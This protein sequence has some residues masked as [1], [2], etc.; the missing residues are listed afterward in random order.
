MI[1]PKP[2][3]ELLQ[4]VVQRVNV[5]VFV[6]DRQY[7]VCY[8]NNFMASHSLKSAFDV[9]GRNLF[10]TF[11]DL[12]V[13][14]FKKKIDSVFVVKSYAFTT[15]E[16]RN[17]LFKFK[18]NRPITG[19]AEYMF[20]NLTLIPIKN[21]SNGDVDQVMV[22]LRDST[23]EACYASKL[24]EAM[25]ELEH[26]SQVDGLTG[27]YNRIHW[28]QRMA[29]EFA[30]SRRYGTT[31]SLL[32]IDIDH[33]KKINDEFGHLAG[34][35]VIRMVAKLI[36]NSSRK[37]DIAGRYGGEEFGILLCETGITGAVI[38][39]ERLRIR[40]ADYALCLDR[41]GGEQHVTVSVG[42]ARYQEGM[43]NHEQVLARS[44]E[45][46]YESKQN[47]RNRVTVCQEDRDECLL[48]TPKSL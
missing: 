38:F 27:L 48:N 42:I 32:M 40:I 6:V 18:H 2:S 14:W 47:G 44:D 31:F 1:D 33:F 28:E 11:P 34:D 39:A 16:Y 46:L 26:L 21:E 19:G 8:W 3:Y 13:R 45:A 43:R 24:R 25:A 10:D 15:W 29:A 9:V 7:T 17:Y 23:D 36:Q 41:Q 20:Q 37:S 4:F 5:G 30:R 12:P 35:D 22:L